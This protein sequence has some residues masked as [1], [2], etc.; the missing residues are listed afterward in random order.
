MCGIAGF[1][2]TPDHD[3]L[4]SMCERIKHRGPDGE[5]FLEKEH[6]SLGHR[7]LAIIDIAHGQEPVSSADGAVH[8]V[9]NGE[10]Y[11]FRELRR[12]L[13]SSGRPFTTSCD[14]E[15]VL[16]AYEQWGTECFALQRH[17]GPGPARRASEGARARPQPRPSGYQA[18]LYG[19]C[20]R[21]PLLRLRDQGSPRG[22]AAAARVDVGR[23]AQY[24][25][26]GLHDHDERTFFEGIHQIRPASA[27]TIELGAGGATTEEI[28]WRPSLSRSAPADPAR[29]REVFTKAV[30]RRLVADVT[31]GTCL[32]GGLDSSSIVCLMS[33]LLAEG[34]PDA[35]SMGEALRTFS[36]VFD[37]DPIDEQQYIAPVLERS[38]AKSDFVRPKSK[39]LFDDLPLLVW[40]Q[41][42]PMVS[43]GPYAQYRVMELAKGKAKVLLDGQGGRAPRR[44]RSL[45]VRV[46]PRAC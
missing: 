9:Y 20:R 14:A 35:S 27:L 34:A 42:E 45:P 46:P 2:G 12:E 7:R 39:D 30:E 8:L 33:T 4:A 38:G 16:A 15:V 44:I 43:S 29:F 41:D 1:T 31:V 40:H 18:S 22:A 11:N 3:L 26:R 37:G 23:L 28:F 25:A 19:P 17:V 13:A 5:G 6:A 21:S 24:L 32:S 10:V 36:A